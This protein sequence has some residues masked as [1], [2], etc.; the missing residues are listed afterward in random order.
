MAEVIDLALHQATL[1]VID[2]LLERRGLGYFLERRSRFPFALNEKRVA[3]AME[4]AS[5]QLG[6]VPCAEAVASSERMMRRRLIAL[7]AEAMIRVGY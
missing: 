6:S 5:R 7:V 2:E 1:R 4:L 3:H